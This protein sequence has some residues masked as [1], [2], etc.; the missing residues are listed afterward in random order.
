MLK[1]MPETLTGKRDWAVLMLGF[2]AAFRRSEIV[3]LTVADLQRTPDG[4]FVL[5]RRSKTDQE[6]EGHIVAIPRGGKLC[7]SRRSRTGSP[8]SASRKAG[9]ST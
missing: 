5:I 3:G 1:K 8:P 7:R 2:T 6:G 4:L 9:S